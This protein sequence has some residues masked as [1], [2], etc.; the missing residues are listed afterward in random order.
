MKL[1]R[2][3]F[4]NQCSL[5]FKNNRIYLDHLKNFHIKEYNEKL[6]DNKFI[7]VFCEKRLTSRQSQWN[8]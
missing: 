4:C 2:K 8:H 7:C 1:T 5:A 6:K 3:N